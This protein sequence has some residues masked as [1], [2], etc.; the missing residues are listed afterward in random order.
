VHGHDVTSC[1][2]LACFPGN[3]NSDILSQL[4]RKLDALYICDNFVNMVAAKKGKIT[5]QNGKRVCVL[6]SGVQPITSCEI[7]TPSA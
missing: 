2:E 6:D 4:L 7:L 5:S 1:C 3:L